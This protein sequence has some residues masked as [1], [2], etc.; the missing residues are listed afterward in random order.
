MVHRGYAYIG[1]GYSN[2]VSVLDM[3]DP[4]AFSG[5]TGAGLRAGPCYGWKPVRVS[6]FRPRPSLALQPYLPYPNS[7]QGTSPHRS[8]TELTQRYHHR[9]RN[10]K[11]ADFIHCDRR[12]FEPASCRRQSTQAYRCTR[13]LKPREQTAVANAGDR[14]A[15]SEEHED[16]HEDDPLMPTEIEDSGKVE[17]PILIG[18]GSR[19]E[20]PAQRE[21]D[22]DALQWRHRELV[23]TRPIGP[24]TT[25]CGYGLMHRDTQA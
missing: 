2:G 20:Q 6:A 3:R 8:G 23:R 16:D 9:D 19:H 21:H 15:D 22:R 17:L 7:C 11:G 24:Q 1:H 5:L 12:R 13:S 25:C 4:R 14:R 18:L 10:Q